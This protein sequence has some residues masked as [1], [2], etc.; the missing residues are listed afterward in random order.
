MIFRNTNIK[1]AYIVT[2]TIQK[3]IAVTQEEDDKQK[4]NGI[5]KLNPALVILTLLMPDS[6]TKEPAVAVMSI[7][8][9]KICS[10]KKIY[11][12][13]CNIVEFLPIQSPKLVV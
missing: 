1:P 5:H 12:Y 11:I 13:I 4:Q 2:N 10:K 9:L 8:I 3:K 6:L 7:K